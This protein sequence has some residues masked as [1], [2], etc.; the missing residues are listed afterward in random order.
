MTTEFP[1]FEKNRPSWSVHMQYVNM[2]EVDYGSQLFICF[3]INI[4]CHIMN[5]Y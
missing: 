2:A 5:H 3:F 4:D 1:S